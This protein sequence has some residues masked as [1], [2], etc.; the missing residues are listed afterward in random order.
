MRGCIERK[1][2]NAWSE[3]LQHTQGTHCSFEAGQRNYH[4][5]KDVFVYA[6]TAHVRNLGAAAL[7]RQRRI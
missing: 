7:N 2:V 4:T 3:Y 5:S 1:G 6:P